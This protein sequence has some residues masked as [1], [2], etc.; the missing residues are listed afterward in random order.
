MKNLLLIN[1]YLTILLLSDTYAGSIHDKR[2]ADAHLYPLPAGSWLLQDLGF[3]GF[4]LPNRDPGSLQKA[5]G[6]PALSSPE[7]LQPPARFPA[8][9]H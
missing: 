9:P 2:L 1:R 7:I 8:H 6:K 3:L 5:K 4:S